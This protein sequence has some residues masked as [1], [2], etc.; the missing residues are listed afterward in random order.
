MCTRFDN[1]P[2]AGRPNAPQ[3]RLSTAVSFGSLLHTREQRRS[4]FILFTGRAI[5]Q[6]LSGQYWKNSTKWHLSTESL[7]HFAKKNR[8]VWR[9][10]EENGASQEVVKVRNILWKNV[11][12]VW[13][14]TEKNGAS[15]VKVRNILW[16]YVRGWYIYMCTGI[17][18]Q[19]NCTVPVVPVQYNVLVL[20]STFPVVLLTEPYST[21]LQPL[22]SM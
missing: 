18:L 21:T 13:R 4:T 10:T 22:F 12:G 6:L 11:R 2:A 17:A 1:V 20:V 5:T 9:A 19:Y 14:A 16:K 3:N 7:Q 8:G 15:V